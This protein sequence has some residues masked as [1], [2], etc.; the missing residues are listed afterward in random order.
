MALIHAYQQAAAR[1]GLAD[2]PALHVAGEDFVRLGRTG[3]LCS[4]VEL[5]TESGP[6]TIDNS[7]GAGAT[8]IGVFLAVK[9]YDLEIAIEQH[10]PRFPAGVAVIS[11]EPLEAE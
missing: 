5:L 6:V 2:M 4:P 9:A 1:S 3:V 8:V 10:V 7:V 11:G